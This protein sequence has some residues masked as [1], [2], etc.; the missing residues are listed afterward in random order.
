MN[1]V[2][3]IARVDVLRAAAFLGVFFYHFSQSLPG[4]GFQWRGLFPDYSKWSAPNYPVLPLEFGWVGVALF[5]VISGFCIHLSLLK[6]IESFSAK[7]FFVRRFLRIYPAYLV[8]MVVVL[9]FNPWFPTRYL[10]GWQVV[11]HLLMVHN[12]FKATF[13]GINTAMWS[14][15]VEWQFYLLVPLLLWGRKKWGL[16]RCLV[17]ALVLNQVSAI[18]LFLTHPAATKPV[19][20]EWSFPLVTWCDW[21]L[22]AC[23]AESYSRGKAL[24]T[25]RGAWLIGSFIA[26]LVT[27]HVR[28]MNVQSYL[29]S[30]I[31]FAV[32]MDG[33]LDTAQPLRWLERVVLV[34][35]GLVS[36]SLYLWHGLAIQLVLKLGRALAW[37]ETS[38]VQWLIYFPLAALLVG[39]VSWAS[40]RFVEVGV[41]R[42][43]KARTRLA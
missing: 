13:Y 35:V 4:W 19:S 3:H 12:L 31:F 22:G 39:A 24:F 37:P 32:L 38:L 26:L 7:S 6:R 18:V 11:T 17:L 29:V 14:L 16:E 30:S 27:L 15:G 43:V 10:N 41:P 1:E 9:A 8:N 20:P 5:F 36:Y 40:F 28:T 34:P 21:I 25:H 33:Y 42:W 23:L 2:R